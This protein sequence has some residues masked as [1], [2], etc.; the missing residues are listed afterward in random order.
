[1]ANDGWPFTSLPSKLNKWWILFSIVICWH[2][3][4]TTEITLQLCIQTAQ[5][6]ERINHSK[7]LHSNTDYKLYSQH[8][9]WTDKIRQLNY[10]HSKNI[11][12]FAFVM[13]MPKNINK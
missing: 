10:I 1:M 11:N 7:Q 6:P 12:T 13:W 8:F 5:Q 2:S 4:H 3:E 9:M